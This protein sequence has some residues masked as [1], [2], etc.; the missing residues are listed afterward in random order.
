MWDGS[1]FSDYPGAEPSKEGVSSKGPESMR[2][3]GTMR[4]VGNEAQFIQA[5]GR[6]S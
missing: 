1:A 2:I 4:I 5:T 3:E 6:T